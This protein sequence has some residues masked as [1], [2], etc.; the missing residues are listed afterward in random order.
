MGLL[1]ILRKQQLKDRQ[2]RVLILG[3]D[4]AGKTTIVNRLLGKSVKDIHPTLGFN[5]ETV[6]RDALTMNIWDVGGQKS[7]RPFWHNYFEKTDCLVWVVDATATDRLTDCKTEL[8]STLNED[9]LSG[10]GLLIFVNKLDAIDPLE[11]SEIVH[12]IQSELDLSSLGKHQFKVLGC[13]AY[14]G[15][16]IEQGFD[17]VVTEAKSRLFIL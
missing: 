5:I 15:F 3:L 8:H 14:T 12:T 6:T 2:I 13:S 10:A 17:W 1:T 4:N 7:L 11:Q 16:N 9:R